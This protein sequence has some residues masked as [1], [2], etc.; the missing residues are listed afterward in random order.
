MP[1]GRDV[2]LAD[3]VGQPG[4]AH[5]PRR[6]RPVGRRS[7]R[8]GHVPGRDKQTSIGCASAAITPMAATGL[9]GAT[10]S[11]SNSAARRVTAS[12]VSS[13]AIRL[14]A[15]TSSTWS[16]SSARHPPGVDQMLAAPG[17]DRLACVT[18]RSA[19]RQR[20]CGRHRAGQGPCDGTR[21]G[22]SSARRP[23]L[24][25]SRTRRN[26]NK[27]TPPNRGHIKLSIKPG[28]HQPVSAGRVSRSRL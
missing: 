5:R 3:R 2:D 25:E 9:L 12:S 28:A 17:V 23:L 21:V 24:K 20:P 22:N 11:F 1:R 4:V 27:P 8:H 26:S 7:S 16:G 19:R 18:P 15:A 13:S 10:A 14:R 6:R